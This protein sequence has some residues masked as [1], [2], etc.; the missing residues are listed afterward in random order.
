MSAS[1]GDAL[2][3]AAS[4]KELESV[5]ATSLIGGVTVGD[6]LGFL[7]SESD[8]MKMMDDL[9]YEAST[10]FGEVIDLL[11]ANETV[12]RYRSESLSIHT[13]VDD[14]LKMVGKKEVEQMI[15]KKASEANY[16][17][18]YASTAANVWKNWIHVLLFVAVFAVA[19]IITLEFIDKDKR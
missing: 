1:A 10:T 13:T 5:R 3:E 6:V 15:V 2:R 19:S 8:I 7:V 9:K 16:N 17:P 14:I 12:K 11:A 18:D 4:S